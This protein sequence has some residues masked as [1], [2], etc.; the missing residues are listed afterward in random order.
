MNKNNEKKR[1]FLSFTSIYF[2]LWE[3]FPF[4]YYTVRVQYMPVNMHTAWYFQVHCINLNM[5]KRIK[6]IFRKSYYNH[7]T[8]V[9]ISCVRFSS[10]LRLFLSSQSSFHFGS[11]S[12]ELRPVHGTTLANPSA[13]FKGNDTRKK[14]KGKMKHYTHL[15]IE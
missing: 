7:F 1:R 5:L 6:S 11:F 9:R 12:P 15:G 3:I 4:Q 13:A 14:K 10:P 8:C 2:R